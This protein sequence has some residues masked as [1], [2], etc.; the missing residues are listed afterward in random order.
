[1]T[2]EEELKELEQLRS[3]MIANVDST[4]QWLKCRCVECQKSMGG[5]LELSEGIIE[6]VNMTEDDFSLKEYISKQKVRDAIEKLS[7]TIAK[8]TLLEHRVITTETLLK[9]LNLGDKNE[10]PTNTQRT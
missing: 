1:M 3:Q 7:R 8:G 6:V 9:E 10:Q 5:K 2:F 4:N